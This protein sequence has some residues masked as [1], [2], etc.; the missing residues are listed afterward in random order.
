[1]RM[2]ASLVA[3]FVTLAEAVSDGS[4]GGAT[5]VVDVI[6]DFIATE[7]GKLSEGLRQAIADNHVIPTRAEVVITDKASPT[8][9]GAKAFYLALSAQ[10]AQG[11]AALCDGKLSPA[12]AK[13]EGEDTRTKEQ[14]A[15]GA[16]DYFNYGKDLDVRADVRSK[17]MSALEGPEKAIK[18]ATDALVANTGMNEAAAREFVVAQRKTAGMPV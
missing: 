16:C 17:L 6:A 1:M 14:A 15:P 13:P 2:I 10:D 12:T 11:M 8:G 9:K 18:K 4:G 3:G 7:S 5:G